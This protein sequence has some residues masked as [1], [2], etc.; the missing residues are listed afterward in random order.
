MMIMERALL[1]AMIIYIFLSLL[2]NPT[3]VM[4]MTMMEVTIITVIYMILPIFRRWQLYNAATNNND[5]NENG[6]YDRDI[7][8][9][10]SKC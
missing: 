3:K 9:N 2:I 5:N 4:I 6:N 8:D 7:D 10:S 1:L